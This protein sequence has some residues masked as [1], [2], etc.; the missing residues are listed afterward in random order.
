MACFDPDQILMNNEGQ[1]FKI[2][3]ELPRQPNC[4]DRYVRVEFLNTGYK[5]DVFLS[6]ALRGSIRDDSIETFN[7]DTTYISTSGRPY[8]ILELT[9]TTGGFKMVKIRFD[10]TGYENEVMLSNALKGFVGDHSLMLFDPNKTYMSYSYGPFKV[11]RRTDLRNKV[12]LALYEVEFL[13][14]GTRI[15]ATIGDINLG[16]IKDPN[17]VVIHDMSILT[18]EYRDK[19]VE[20]SLFNVW[21]NMLERCYNTKQRF[22]YRYG[23]IGVT[24]Q[25]SWRESYQNFREDV[26]E[27]PQYDKYIN[28]FYVYDFDKD[29]RQLNVPKEKRVYSKDTCMFLHYYDNQNLAQ[30]EKHLN[31]TNTNKYYGVRQT[32]PKHFVMNIMCNRY[33][34][35]LAFSNEIAAANAYNYW[36]EVWHTYE[37]IPLINEVPYMPPEEWS[38]YI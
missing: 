34:R 18:K 24:V 12:H 7:R 21:Y 19:F 33:E 6:N 16:K 11:L 23:G 10:E 30:L 17:G 20:K 22:Y 4:H 38:K 1:P 27:I 9:G 5:K 3:E 13:Y 26:Q 15:L 14:T 8:H 37:L 35:R 36:Q 32:S 25:D 28:N 2:I 29:Y 31:G